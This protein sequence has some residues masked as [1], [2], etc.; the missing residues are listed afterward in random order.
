MGPLLCVCVCV[1]DNLL[2]ITGK[3]GHDR[4]REKF[5][6]PIFQALPAFS[7]VP[8]G[9]FQ[10][11]HTHLFDVV[12]V[13]FSILF[14]VVRE[15]GSWI[16]YCEIRGINGGQ[17]NV[18]KTAQFLHMKDL[19]RHQFL[20]HAVVTVV[21]AAAGCCCCCMNL[22]TPPPPPLPL[23]VGVIRMSNSSKIYVI[24]TSQ[25]SHDLGQ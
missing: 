1:S 15:A 9:L 18:R 20:I 25:L 12:I 21:A 24:P 5:P 2:S 11:T 17:L 8:K 13:R 22:L 19:V 23:Q 7:S 14:I 3:I 4:V 16:S 6:K 10:H